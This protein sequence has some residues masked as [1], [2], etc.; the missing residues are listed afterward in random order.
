MTEDRKHES[1]IDADDDDKDEA[2]ESRRSS[3]TLEQAIDFMTESNGCCFDPTHYHSFRGVSFLLPLRRCGV[4]SQRLQSVVP[5][6]GSHVV[7]CLACQMLAH[8]TCAMS[9]H[10]QWNVPCPVNF[11]SY[12]TNGR[13][14]SKF[15]SSQNP[16]VMV[17]QD[18]SALDTKE[19][20]STTH[21]AEVLRT[22]EDNSAMRIQPKLLNDDKGDESESDS[23]VNRNDRLSVFRVPANA[24]E[25]RSTESSLSSSSS[26]P[27]PTIR[28]VVS[29]GLAIEN[30]VV[31][32]RT[33]SKA[34]FPFLSA[35][36]LFH[37]TSE[38]FSNPM[39]PHD[40]NTIKQDIIDTDQSVS[41]MIARSQTWSGPET[42]TKSTQVIRE[43]QQ[44][45]FGDA[46]RIPDPSTDH[47]STSTS[48]QQQASCL[49]E[50]PVPSSSSADALE[51]T[52]EG[53]PAHWATGKSLET[54]FPP[55]P[56]PGETDGFGDD[57]T[58][59][60]EDGPLHFSSH[61]FASVSRAL[62]E[63]I[64]VHFRPVVERILVKEETVSKNVD[65]SSAPL[66]ASAQEKDL[67][68][69][70]TSS[71]NHNNA[72]I[73]AD[74]RTESEVEG[75]L[76]EAKAPGT[77]HRRLG[78]ATVAGGIAGGVA[79][80]VF[81]GP[82]GGVIGAKFGQTFGILG[83]VL[84]GSLTIGVITSGIAAGRHAGQQLQ[85]KI[86]E[87]RV[88][89][90]GGNGTNQGII[91]VRPTV[92]TDPA[93]GGFCE[94]AKRLHHKKGLPFNFLPSDSKAAKRERYE[95]EIDIVTTD[96]IEIPTG[97]KVL[98]L[99]SR[100]LNNKESMPGHV[101]RQLIE[102]VR[103][104][105]DQRG[106]LA[107]ILK[108]HFELR[109]KDDDDQTDESTTEMIR[110]RRQDA[111]AAIKYITATLLEIRPGFA[112]SPSITEYTATA[113]EG[114]VFGEI[115]DLVIEEIEAEFEEKEN[116]LLEKVAA[117]ERIHAHGGDSTSEH[118][119][120]ISEEAL[121]ALHNLPEAHSAV[122][123][124]R[125]CVTFLEKI[126]EFF[127]ADANNGTKP[128]GADSLLK[129]VCQ[130]ILAAKV[131]GINAQIAFLDEFARDEQ[132]LR[133]KEG[134]ALVTLQASL[135]FLNASSDFHSD[136]FEQ[137]DD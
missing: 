133:G 48:M 2:A 135:H 87:K 113:V 70:T 50:Q 98:L 99:V 34:N 59:E 19:G 10:T 117:F 25:E 58:G 45:S 129:L 110:A 44:S 46:Q 61:P 40:T 33:F 102:K 24:Q 7:Q 74:N 52:V 85:D 137:E 75:L 118:K 69:S 119:N 120:H 66:S 112:A 86:D 101:Y 100:I 23:V 94:E 29:E 27:R 9:K 18:E 131:F 68:E 12:Q 22:S 55:K 80:M 82:V 3:S 76:E 41:M 17:D 54:M 122:D 111:H 89:A 123:K 104:R 42:C 106:P 128:M 103:E 71:E 132:L 105:A 93:W 126:S 108:A 21:N 116:E 91:L 109:Q 115:Y 53:P 97:D 16:H 64:L 32:R 130:H 4:C 73:N 5:F 134:Y 51:W 81:A 13:E 79:G 88:L 78:L 43:P 72:S 96:E 84:E 39:T 35:S 65:D 92:K 56:P 15:T 67:E 77:D 30:G 107:E 1:L 95:R 20:I 124:L 63:N 47:V 125:Y 83:V 6:S 60:K 136:I 36:S 49:E 62:H 31:E 127:S 57:A 14:E 37:T 8:R 28:S 121:E 38:S 11:Q 26:P 90:L 114:L